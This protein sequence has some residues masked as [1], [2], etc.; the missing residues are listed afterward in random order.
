MFNNK[1]RD[2][3]DHLEQPEI[4]PKSNSS[5]KAWI[6]VVAFI[7]IAVFLPEQAAQ[8]MEYDWRVLWQKPA[9]GSFTPGYLRDLRN[10]D[11]A[12]A[13]KNILKDIANKPIT[14]IK[15][16]SNLTV[17]L[18]KPL[19]MSNQRIEEI[20]NWLKG[21]PCGT[22]ALYDFLV[23]QGN[24]VEEQDIA[25]MALTV[26][27]LSEVVKP[28]GDPQVIKNSLFALSKTSEFYGI[29][30]YPVKVDDAATN[31]I[32]YP[33]PF[34][35]HLDSDHYVLVTR[36]DNDKVYYSDQHREEFLPKEKFLQRFSG[37][38][39]MLAV[40]ENAALLSVSEAK[41]ILGARR[42]SE[43]SY[44]TSPQVT[45]YV[46]QVTTSLN[47]DIQKARNQALSRIGTDLAISVGTSLV[48]AWVANGGLGSW[49]STGS[50][51]ASSTA[52]SYARY[53][54]TGAAA[55]I[56]VNGLESGKFFGNNWY[57]YAAG[58]A[59]AGLGARALVGTSF[60]QNTVT[61]AWNSVTNFLSPAFDSHNT[62]SWLTYPAI[63]AAGGIVLHGISTG[64]WFSG[65]WDTYAL[66][67]AG[68]GL[69]M[70]TISGISDWYKW[71]DSS[72]FFNG[73]KF[74]D[75][76]NLDIGFRNYYQDN[77]GFDPGRDTSV[78]YPRGAT[79]L[80]TGLA[81][82][83]VST[84]TPDSLF[85]GFAHGLYNS[86]AVY[87]S[88]NLFQ[89]CGLDT[90]D[91]GYAAAAL[92]GG[93][94]GL[95]DF[96]GLSNINNGLGTGW[97]GYTFSAV[98]GALTNFTSA[99]VTQTL[100]D[101]KIAQSQMLASYLGSL[102]GFTVNSLF[103]GTIYMFN[104]DS[105][106]FDTKTNKFIFDPQAIS[107]AG[108][109]P[110]DANPLSYL[111]ANIKANET[112]L[113]RGAI[114]NGVAEFITRDPSIIGLTKDDLN[115]L[116][117][118][119][120]IGSGISSIF[121]YNMLGGSNNSTYTQLVAQG[122]TGAV[123]TFVEAKIEVQILKN[124]PSM[125]PI[126]A[127]FIADAATAAGRGLMDTIFSSSTTQN[128][129]DQ[130]SNITSQTFSASTGLAGVSDNIGDAF[131]NDAA[132]IISFGY[133]GHGNGLFD[134][135]SYMRSTTT[136]F[137]PHQSSLWNYEISRYTFSGHLDTDGKTVLVTLSDGTVAKLTSS[138]SNYYTDVAGNSW[139]SNGNGKYSII[140]PEY[141]DFNFFVGW[142]EL[143]HDTYSQGAVRNM[144]G[145]ISSIPGVA[146]ALGLP[147]SFMTRI[148][149][150]EGN[151]VPVRLTLSE[152]SLQNGNLFTQLNNISLNNVWGDNI[153]N[154]TTQYQ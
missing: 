49:F 65:N 18:D 23:Y 42:D 78:V 125:T 46:N 20:F 29:K 96:S 99:Y 113:I 56:V 14:S 68:A 52:W 11:T 64:Q 134:D 119:T 2:D 133:I 28:E 67:G 132:K 19:K 93:L 129:R 57:L 41:K 81:S 5:F 152:T 15:I 59:A 71:G 124:N 12:L 9:I 35:A 25:I 84:K 21:R 101:N 3:E 106:A 136:Y 148:V 98:S 110:T 104:K 75:N 69:G 90:K 121:P 74:I 120:A 40:P 58:G 92:S 112:S 8:A 76:Y 91:A 141:S 77:F 27:I 55:G 127:A 144:T 149:D 150:N 79:D 107:N 80:T 108:L 140:K 118:A 143:A 51:T 82:L 105:F 61:P 126:M 146:S 47:N 123:L 32:K 85:S 36:V 62:L 137:S 116:P 139:S 117:Y 103:N 31:L 17:D 142:G 33:V 43:S 135:I 73:Q 45:N 72:A 44:Y 13:I 122:L 70:R 153:F 83:N 95:S 10:I 109:T 102:A 60:W 66:I 34:I 53:A 6:R 94:M 128:I 97:T 48:G 138:G 37:N 87:L 1:P 22:K 7:V 115:M 24:K 38:A 131:G 16:S 151:V 154:Q 88:S 145:M 130:N 39:L 50:G 63:G 114:S 26:D 89:L 54:I 111:W 30:T 147:T 86:Q 4:K 100:L